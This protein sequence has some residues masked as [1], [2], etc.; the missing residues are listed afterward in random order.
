MFEGMAYAS[1][2]KEA[3]PPACRP[4]GPS[5]YCVLAPCSTVADFL[6]VLAHDDDPGS[7]AYCIRH[8]P[9]DAEVEICLAARQRE[10][11]L[12]ELRRRFRALEVLAAPGEMHC[13]V[14]C[15]SFAVAN[16]LRRALC[17]S[18]DVLACDALDVETH[19]S[20]HTDTPAAHRFGQLAF[21]GGAESAIAKVSVRG[22]DLY[23]R[24]ICWVHSEG[25]HA[26][27]CV[28]PLDLDLCIVELEPGA[29]FTATLFLVRGTPLRHAKFQSVAA[30]TYVP[31]VWLSRAPDAAE[32]ARLGDYTWRP[33][34]LCTR[35]DGTVCRAERLREILPRLPVTLGPR[36]LLGI[37]SLGQRPAAD[38]VRLALRSLE[39]GADTLV[40]L[41]RCCDS[42][43]AGAGSGDG[44]RATAQQ[45]PPH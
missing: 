38:C 11:C 14:A 44:G 27:V 10:R 37:E 23:A 5:T 25:M 33:E 26:D 4:L 3:A 8:H 7:E 31:D 43:D 40:G 24:D 36:V 13:Q 29:E 16:V 17:T 1:A 20:A 45:R 41:L 34:G 2:E 42:S 12:A 21:R 6:V 35:A 32:S 28:V 9:H 19:S 30:P 39:E 15:P 22:R 18:L